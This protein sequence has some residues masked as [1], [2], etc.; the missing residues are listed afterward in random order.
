MRTH[1]LAV[2]ALIGLGALAMAIVGCY[3]GN[4][5]AETEA[6][7]FLSVDLP[8]VDPDV[9]MAEGLDVTIATMTI[10]SHAKSPSVTLSTQQDVVLDRWV[11]TCIRSDGGTVASPQWQTAFTVYVP[12][13]GSAN[14]LNARIFPAENFLQAP[15]YQLFPGNSGFDKETGNTNIRQILH[16]EAFGKTVAGKA[17][18]VTFDVNY[19]FSFL[20]TGVSPTPTPTPVPPTPTP[21]PRG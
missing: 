17:I 12:A 5:T 19:N 10:S 14:V 21:T 15:L 7:V 3:D 1:R 8:S 4:S 13:S 20:G 11:I 16:I 9:I 18:S 6:P 2:F